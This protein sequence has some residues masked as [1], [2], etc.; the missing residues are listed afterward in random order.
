[1]RFFS[2]D[3]ILIL[4]I[5]EVKV[6]DDEYIVQYWKVNTMFQKLRRVA[7]WLLS[8]P[9]S[10]ASNE[11]VFSATGFTMNYRRSELSGSTLA[12]LTFV[13]HNYDQ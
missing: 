12:D 4:A 2:P 3:H 13:H 11:R 8:I 10:S 7:A 5:D 1:M 6:D 9:A